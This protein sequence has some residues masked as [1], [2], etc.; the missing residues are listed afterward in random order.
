MSLDL[1]LFDKLVTSMIAAQ[2]AYSKSFSAVWGSEDPS[3][4]LLRSN[5]TATIKSSRKA[6]LALALALALS[7]AL[8]LALDLALGLALALALAPALALA[9]A[10]A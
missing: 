2:E 8:A 1:K 5:T 3:S 4:P 9:L 6:L 7:L 10:L